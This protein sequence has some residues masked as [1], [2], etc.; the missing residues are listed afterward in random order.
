LGLKEKLGCLEL[1]VNPLI[2]VALLNP[3]QD[4]QKHNQQKTQTQR[5]GN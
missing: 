4:G 5:Q 2:D 3:K 1:A